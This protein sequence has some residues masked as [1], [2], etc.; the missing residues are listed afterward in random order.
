MSD[1]IIEVVN[2]R[3]GYEAVLADV[4]YSIKN[5]EDRGIALKFSGYSDKLFT[6]V[7]VFVDI[8]LEHSNSDKG[9]EHT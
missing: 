3:C 6:F 5:C 9:F 4:S 2:K 8:L 7:N 1:C